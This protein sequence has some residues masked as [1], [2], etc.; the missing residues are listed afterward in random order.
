M[1][2]LGL[3]FSP[4]ASPEVLIER[5]FL[6]LTGLPPTPEQVNTFVSNPSDDA[7]AA[8][9]EQLLNSPRYGERWGRH[10]LDIAGYADS[11]GYSN[12][13]AD[14]PWAYFYR[15][16]VISSLNADKPLD[17]FIQEQIAGDEMVSPPYSN[18][19]PDQI[20]KLTATGFLRMAADGTGSG[21]NDETARN[22]TIADTIK[23]VSTSLLGLSVGCAQCHDHRYDP[24]PQSD[25]YSLRA[26]FAPALNHQAWRTPQQRL[27]SL[28][29]DADRIS[30]A[31]VEAEAQEIAKQKAEKQTAYL[32]E[33]LEVELA[34]HPEALREPL[35][36]AYKAPA[37]KRTDEQKGLLAMYPSVNIS[38]GTLYQYNQGHAD[39]LKAFD[40]RIAEIRA[41]KPAEHFLRTLTETPGQVPA[42][43]VFHRGDLQQPTDI[44]PP[45]A[46]SISAPPGQRAVFSDNDP[47]LPTSG[48][49]LAYARWLTSNAHPLLPR[50]MA[51]RIWLHHFGR[52]IVG[53]PSDFG[54]LGQLPT[55]PK[56]LD[57]LAS[58]LK[59]QNWS[60]KAMH[61]LIV[62]STVYRQSGVADAS[63]LA[64]DP[65]NQFYWKWPV[66]RLEAE[67]LRDKILAVNG[68]LSDQMY[69]PSVDVTADETGQVR[70]ADERPRRSVYIKVKRTQPVAVLQTFDAPVM[71]VN[72]EVRPTSTVAMQSLMLMNSEFILKQ[73]ETFANR[74]ASD[75]AAKESGDPA[76]DAN[77]VPT[78]DTWKK[79]VD[80][81]SFRFDPSPWS[82]GYG[83]LDEKEG[84]VSEFASLPHWTGASWQGGPSLPDP[85]LGYVL[86]N[87][88]GGHPSDKHAA[89]RRYTVLE[90]GTVSVSGKLSHSSEHGDGV[91]GSLVSSGGGVIAQWSAANQGVDTTF[92]EIEV[93]AG[94]TIDFVVDCRDNQT[95]DSF[96]WPV[97]LQVKTASRTMAEESV[98]GF[99]GPFADPAMLP[100]QIALAWRLAYCRE[101]TDQ[102]LRNALGFVAEQLQTLKQQGTVEGKDPIQQAMTN[103]CQV[104][105]G[106]NEFLYVD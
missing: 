40:T 63:K 64:I 68:S 26:I 59:R 52:G 38:A 48:R 96:Q 97:S 17:Q 80:A 91:R 82:F 19:S 105:L 87:A 4:D 60:L 35:R 58:E 22:Q 49:R 57:W 21:S 76:T 24:I 20:E 102:E 83:V 89:I 93:R 25:Y 75:A 62:S 51:N 16:Y 15:D 101:V 53:T 30:A 98:K 13:D 39:E 103:L 9:I 73:A 14:R 43:H 81:E 42:T 104:L 5:L 72:C 7:Y 6:D 92:A 37:D 100:S 90:A 106:S 78:A 27:V 66:I 99:H 32:D 70:V 28:Y 1:Q 34:K 36:A 94:D 29:T 95:S 86:L 74:L 23:I 11:E 41:K 61:R 55:H 46:L 8:L 18:L 44:V 84:K 71:E 12:A 33:A 31:K 65:A 54:R 50:V 67:A 88:S 3:N 56:L 79:L 47:E 85:Q 10:W 77:G 2:P 69:G 45:A